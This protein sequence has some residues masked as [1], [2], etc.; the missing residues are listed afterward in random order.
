MT[1][2]ESA[3]RD[4]APAETPTYPVLEAPADGVPDIVEDERRLLEAAAA[5]GAGTGPVALD[6][7]RASGYRY[8]SRAYLVQIRR[9]GSGSWLIDPIAC[10]DLGPIQDAIGDAEWVLHAATQDLPCLA[11]VGLRP[12]ALFDTELGSRLA[13]LP[14]VGLAAVIEHYLGISLAKEHSAV[15]W[16][17]RPLPEPWLTYAALDVEVLVEV[18]NR[19][20]ADLE[21]Q[22]KLPWALEE[23]EALTSFTGPPV[24]TDPWRRTSGMHKVRD[25]RA[26]ARVR[27]L[28]QTRDDIAR[29]RDISPGRVLPDAVLVEIAVRAPT[30]PAALTAA[31]AD[32]KAGTSRRGKARPPHRS[33]ARYQRDWL[34]AVRRVNDLADADLPPATVRS[35]APPP[36]RA[37]ADRDPVASARLQQV[38]DE[39]TA[40]S[41]REQIPVE[42]LL[43]PDFLRRVLWRPPTPADRES[44]AEALSALGARPWQVSL[45][46]P[47]IVRA[48]SDHPDT[49]Q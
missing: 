36:Q 30:T 32:S 46:A 2:V 29:K 24:R 4:D 15:D 12:S 44:V 27:E 5:I 38:R 45:A 31:T 8:G 47:L 23:F 28:W 13:G 35:D 10:P 3:G 9:E 19:L 43:T 18:R 17:T 33:I 25:R 41:E 37:W 16:S 11:E 14:R 6:A 20:R 7:E 48:I 42:N 39:L 21:Q 22:G 34:D 1:D 26:V 49:D 40:F